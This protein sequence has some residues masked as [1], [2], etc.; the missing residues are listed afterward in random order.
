[1][2]GVHLNELFQREELKTVQCIESE[3]PSK[4]KR[5]KKKSQASSGVKNVER[6][7]L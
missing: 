5:K 3:S 2:S 7:A 4:R 1:V 6:C